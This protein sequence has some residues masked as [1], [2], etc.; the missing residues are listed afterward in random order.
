MRFD[1]AHVFKNITLADYENL[2]FDDS[3]NEAMKPV[4]GLKKRETLE[5]REENGKLIKKTRVFPER[6]FPGPIKKLIDGELSYTEDSTFD[7]AT[8]TLEFRSKVSVLSDKIKLGGTIHFREVAGGIER[9]IV[10]E[11]GVSVFGLG[12]MIEKAIVDNLKETYD[13]IAKFTQEW[14]DGNKARS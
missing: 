6:D 9:R 14:I 8:H 4:A 3:F 7:R 13:K 5:R 12:G 2:F 11:A 1:I 10:G